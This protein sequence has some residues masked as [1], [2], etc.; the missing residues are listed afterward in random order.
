M[1][2]M[3]RSNLVAVKKNKTVKWYQDLPNE[4]KNAVTRLAIERRRDVMM[5]HHEESRVRSKQR[6]DRMQRD[7]Q[8]RIAMRAKEKDQL[9]Q[10]HVITTPDEL[11]SA[12]EEIDAYGCSAPSKRKKKLALIRLQINIRKKVYNQKIC[13]PFTQRGKNRAT[14]T[15]IS[16]F[17]ESI[18]VN[19]HHWVHR[20]VPPTVIH[21]P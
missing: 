8:R 5:Q 21:F 16:E 2:Q 19:P 20:Q 15:I 1:D 3:T 17:Q 14:G 10:E 6:Q 11:V 7:H 12:L 9:S 4:K 18:A 13:I